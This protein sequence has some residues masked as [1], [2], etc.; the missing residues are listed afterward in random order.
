MRTRF[1]S[2][3]LTISALFALALLAGCGGGDSSGGSGSDTDPQEILQGALGGDQQIDSGVLDLTFD[4]AST[5]ATEGSLS[6][7]LQG[8]FQSGNGQL[9]QLDLTASASVDAATT[10][11]DF[12]GGLTITG[13]GAYVS[14]N[15]TDYQVDDQTFALLQQSYE[16]SSQLQEQSGSDQGSLQAF[17][18]DP[19]NWVTDLTNEGTE[20]LDGTE[21]VHV[22]GTADV[23]TIV[24]DLEKI[25]E[26]T[27]QASQIDQAGLRQVQDSVTNATIDVYAN[28]DD[29]SLRKIDLSVD[30]ANPGGDGATTVALSIGIAD[31]N[32]DQQITAPEDAQPIADLLAQIPGGAEALGGLGSLGGSSGASASPPGGAAAGDYYDCAAGAKSEADLQACAELLAP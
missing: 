28:T 2:L 9:P 1:A 20:D 16:Q 21:V 19:A 25:A 11:I 7:S 15:G 13:D 17:G 14:Y 27:G 18:V 3:I 22:S 6:A 8:P 10:T 24:A 29:N 32:T 23:P 4:L 31:P 30:I 26:Q 5:G 12:D